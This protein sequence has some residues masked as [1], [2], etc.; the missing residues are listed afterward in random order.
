[1][2][3]VLLISALASVSAA[4]LEQPAAVEAQTPV[5]EAAVV[6]QTEAAPDGEEP[7]PRTIQDVLSEAAPYDPNGAAPADVKAEA[8]DGASENVISPMAEP[9]PSG[10]PPVQYAAPPPG[11]EP[12]AP[13]YITDSLR[14]GQSP[15]DALYEQRVLGVFRSAQG[16]QGA[17]DGRW[18]VSGANGQALYA[19]QMADPG[20][21]AER[22]EGAWLNPDKNGVGRSGLVETVRQEESD[23]VVRFYQNGAYQNPA[24]LRIRP[25]A[26]G[27]T[28]EAVTAAGRVPISLKRDLGVE[29]AA[30]QVPSYE[31]PRVAPT[32]AKKR[33]ARKKAKAKKNR[34]SSGQRRARAKRG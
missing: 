15:T 5:V 3:L 30:L 14:D 2:N 32:K 29:L 10:E 1:V 11:S 7:Q 24:E 20:A 12:Q 6:V 31:P 18:L 21:G 13:R 28:G 8:T 23:L 22:I 27:W 17:F 9:E 26:G 4:Q 34:R 25:T 16:R 33:P 19:L